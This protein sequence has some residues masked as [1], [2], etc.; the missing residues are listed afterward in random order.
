MTT[1][2]E[3]EVHAHCLS[4]V[5][6]ILFSEATREAFVFTYCQAKLLEEARGIESGIEY[7]LLSE[8]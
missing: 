1:A 4:V 7:S 8:R 5:E 3:C 2:S 6:Y